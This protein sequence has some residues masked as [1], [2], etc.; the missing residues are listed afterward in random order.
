MKKLKKMEEKGFYLL[1][2]V[3]AANSQLFEDFEEMNKFQS[4][5]NRYLSD[6]MYIK[7]YCLK[8]DGWRMIVRIKDQRTVNTHFEAFKSN[9]KNRVHAF[10]ELWEKLSEM[11]RICLNQYARWVNLKRNREGKLFGKTYK[12]S[13]FES[14]EE[15]KK[16]I[17][18]IRDEKIEL[19]QRN[20]KFRP[21]E[22]YYDE[23]GEIGKNSWITSSKMVQLGKVILQEIGLKCLYLWEI[24]DSVLHELVTFTIAIYEVQ[25]TTPQ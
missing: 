15:A 5:V 21:D 23:S 7:E 13:Y 25:K 22:K 8:P 14:M 1:E 20:P 2:G 3:A 19:S 6:Y 11:V 10:S 12:R 18:N 16:E 17:T 4:M 24:A 9:S